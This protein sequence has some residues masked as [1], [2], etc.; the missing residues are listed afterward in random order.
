VFAGAGDEVK[1]PAPRARADV[2]S[3]HGPRPP[4]TA[5]DEQVLVGDAGRVEPDSRGIL[6]VE[7][8]AQL[9]G[10]LVAEAADELAGLWA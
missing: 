2:E 7:A 1:D 8:A 10:A 5:D 9:N 3:T 6:R 4:E